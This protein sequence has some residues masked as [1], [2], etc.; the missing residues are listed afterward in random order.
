VKNDTSRQLFDYI[1]AKRAGEEFSGP[2]SE[3][4][5]DIVDEFGDDLDK[6]EQEAQAIHFLDHV[7][8]G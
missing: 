5:R 7:L 1:R 2:L 3:E 4:A 6:L 8:F